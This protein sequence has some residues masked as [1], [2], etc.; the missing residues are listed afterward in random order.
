MGRALRLL[1]A[2]ADSPR[3]MSLSQLAASAQIDKSG[4]QRLANT[5][6]ALGYL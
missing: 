5:L 1:E 3:P 6:V 2:F 4:A